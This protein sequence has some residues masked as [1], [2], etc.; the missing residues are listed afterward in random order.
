MKN[1]SFSPASHAQG[2]TQSQA[3]GENSAMVFH[4][5]CHSWCWWRRGIRGGSGVEALPVWWPPGAG[6]ALVT[7]PDCRFQLS[8]LGQMLRRHLSVVLSLR[9]SALPDVRTATSRE[10]GKRDFPVSLPSIRPSSLFFTVQIK[11]TRREIFPPPLSPLLNLYIYIFWSFLLFRVTSPLVPLSPRS[12]LPHRP[13]SLIS[14]L[15]I[16]LSNLFNH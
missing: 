9:G 14:L 16:S 15:L 11:T 2:V 10:V 5:C 12:L 6:K 3:Q 4:R 7:T 8:V 13:H 1:F